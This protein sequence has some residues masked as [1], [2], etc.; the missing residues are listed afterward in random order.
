MSVLGKIEKWTFDDPPA[1]RERGRL[2]AAGILLA[3]AVTA[4]NGITE[5]LT[6]FTPDADDMTRL[7][8]FAMAACAGAAIG[9]HRTGTLDAYRAFDL[10]AIATAA[11]LARLCD[12]GAAVI[13]YACWRIAWHAARRRER[14]WWIRADMHDHPDRYPRTR[15]GDLVAMYDPATHVTGTF[16]D[17][18][19][20]TLLAADY[21][22]RPL[23]RRM[24]D[25]WLHGKRAG[26]RAE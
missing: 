12:P 13:A 20:G 2:A 23:R 7:T 4:A 19:D 17:R 3:I 15:H 22:L 5:R 21:T 25:E 10:A 14:A 26:E 1:M 16:I 24:L 11:L 6:G 9:H 18:G 8:V